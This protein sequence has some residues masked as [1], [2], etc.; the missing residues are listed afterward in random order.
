MSQ[1]SNRTLR[2][3]TSRAYAGAVATQR[4]PAA[5]EGIILAARLERPFLLFG[6]DGAPQL[7]FF[8]I[9]TKGPKRSLDVPETA[10]IAVSLGPLRASPRRLLGVG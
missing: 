6:P 4:P 1:V 10:A 9:G 5:S 3:T 7:A 8:A 2:K